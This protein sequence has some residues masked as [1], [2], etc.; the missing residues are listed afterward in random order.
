MERIKR[1][2]AAVILLSL[3]IF[4]FAGCAT[5]QAR[6]PLHVKKVTYVIYGGDINH[7]EVY[8]ITS[9]RKVTQYS[10]DPEA[11]KRYDYIAGEFP[12]EDKYE[13]KEYEMTE[14][15][16]TSMVNVLT[17]VNFMEIQEDLNATGDIC[18]ACTYYIKVET[19]DASHTAGGYAAGM[20]EGYQ[21]KNF[22]EARQYITSALRNEV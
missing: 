9:D 8:V 11:D 7:D 5:K 1:A 20:S 18:D 22:A 19:S 2:I 12:S 14:L 6:G 4:S 16:W 17:R 21:H 10:V 13:V 3:S 15:S